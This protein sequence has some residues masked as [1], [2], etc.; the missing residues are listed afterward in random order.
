M[1]SLTTRILRKLG[2]RSAGRPLITAIPVSTFSVRRGTRQVHTAYRENAWLQAVVDT[3]AESVATPR[4]RVYRVKDKNS[5]DARA[6]KAHILHEPRAEERRKAVEEAERDGALYEVRG[7][8]LQQVLENPH[9][10]YPGRELRKLMAIHCDLSGETFQWLSRDA[11]GSVVG[12]HVLPPT[13]VQLTPTEGRP[14][15]HVNYN[16]MSGQVPESEILWIRHLDPENPEGRGVGRGRA[17]GDELDTSEAIQR[18]VKA[19]FERGGLPIATIGVDA[20]DA[21][22]DDTEDW[23]KRYE[24]KHM[25]ASNAGKVLFVPGKV[26]VSSLSADMRSLQMVETDKAIR[27]FVR[28]IYN[29][30]PELM[31]DLTSANRST[32]DEAKYTLAQYAT[33]PRLEFFRAWW[34]LLM[35]PQVDGDAILE[36]DDPRPQSWERKHKAMTSAY[37]EAFQLNEARRM[38][39]L[40]PDPELEGQRFKPLP[41]AQPI[42]D[43]PPSEPQNQPPA[44]GPARG[45]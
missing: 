15:F 26:S 14:T 32:S 33:I 24:E 21:A 7:H 28:Q 10:K 18:G 31:G 12:F 27:D 38:A 8:R 4:W 39:G 34:Q 19:T 13:A 25:G 40:P 3:V 43:G 6:L 16:L 1:A 36:Y 45:A 20:G 44:R 9:P 5:T 11:T 42:Q 35:V 23:E 2:L 29:V 22:E 30:S 41:G 37:N 17:A